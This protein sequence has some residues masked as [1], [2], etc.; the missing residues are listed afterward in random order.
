MTSVARS[1]RSESREIDVRCSSALPRRST[2][3][4]RCQLFAGHDGPHAIMYARNG[5]RRVQLWKKRGEPAATVD[6]EVAAV[7]RPWMFGYPVP[8]WFE[9]REP[10]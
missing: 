8:A 5:E 3:E 10:F 1:F 7:Q 2:S 4:G 6:T 9:S